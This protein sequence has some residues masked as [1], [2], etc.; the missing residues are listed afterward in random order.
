MDG[1]FLN[2]ASWQAVLQIGIGSGRGF[3]IGGLPKTCIEAVYQMLIFRQE[4]LFF[5][6][7]RSLA[8]STKS[9]RF[10]FRKPFPP[11]NSKSMFT[12]IFI[13]L[14]LLAHAGGNGPLEECFP[15]KG[16]KTAK[17][18]GKIKLDDRSQNER[19]NEVQ[20]IEYNMDGQAVL[21]K[22]FGGEGAVYRRKYRDGKL[23]FIATTRKKLP[24][25]Y[26]IE[27]LD[28][29]IANSESQTDTAFIV[30]HHADGR[31]FEMVQSDGTTWIFEY[32]G[33]SMEMT[34]TLSPQGDTIQQVQTLNKNGVPVEVIWTPFTPVKSTVVTRRFS[35]Y[36][37][38]KRGHWIKRTC[39]VRGGVLTEKRELTYY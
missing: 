14:M 38:N 22:E 25:F 27:Q 18:I 2:E 7:L 23:Q 29:L 13:S 8:K 10:H 6:W 11:I 37:F 4:D 31:P 16:V 1:N 24:N 17:I 28:S 5:N 33:C 3:L 32:A 39:H 21:I 30:R 20:E 26:P 15:D 36:K 35:G 12:Y 19:P 9:H 34:T